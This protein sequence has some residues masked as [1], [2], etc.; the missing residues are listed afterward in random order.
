MS[1]L[2]RVVIIED[3]EWL[4]EHMARSLRG[5]GFEPHVAHHSLEAI[6]LI[7]E[8]QPAAIVL[9]VLLPGNTGFALLHELQSHADLASIPVVL[10]TNTAP[11]LTTEQLKPYGVVRLVD[12]STMRPE[13][14]AANVRGALA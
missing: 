9:D 1:R 13:D 3:D 12:K 11:D 14:I 2:S 6:S 10:C 5:E 8:V 4:A 7:D